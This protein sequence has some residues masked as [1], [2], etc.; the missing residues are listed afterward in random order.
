VN[1]SAAIWRRQRSFSTTTG[2]WS[3]SF[4]ALTVPEGDRPAGELVEPLERLDQMPVERIAAHLAVGHHV[5]PG[6]LLERDRLV[7]RAI[8]DLLERRRRQLAT[9][10]RG[11]RLHQGSGPE[12]ASNHVG[13]ERLHGQRSYPAA[14]IVRRLHALP[15]TRA[16]GCQLA[17]VCVVPSWGA[18]A[19]PPARRAVRRA[20]IEQA[21]RDRRC[22]IPLLESWELG[23]GS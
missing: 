9:L 20:I 12:E 11:A 5:E 2:R 14:P 22:T 3:A 4:V 23:V 19:L 17:A 13:S 10:E 16:H 18:T 8:F 7:H 21:A 15:M 1:S 6:R